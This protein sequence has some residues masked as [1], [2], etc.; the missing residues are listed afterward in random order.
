M[1]QVLLTGN[2]TV[3]TSNIWQSL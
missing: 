2:F 3:C 1:S